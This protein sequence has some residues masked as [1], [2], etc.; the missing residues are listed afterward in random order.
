MSPELA[1][2]LFK[3]PV[4]SNTGLGI[5]LFQA[6]KQARTNDYN[7]SLLKNQDGRVCFVLKNYSKAK[8]EEMQ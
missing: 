2:T 8:L 3:D 5:G 4:K 7:L 1:Q 6:A